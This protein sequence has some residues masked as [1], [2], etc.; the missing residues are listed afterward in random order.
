MIKIRL[1]PL[2][3]LLIGLTI[4]FIV[5][6]SA[7]QD[8]N[9]LE[10]QRF[11]S[12]CLTFE[13]KI[14]KQ[15]VANAQ[16][17]YSS[18]AFIASSDTI[19]RDEWQEFQFLN[20]SHNELL[21]IQG[22]GYSIIVGKKDLDKLEMK[23]QKEG[24]PNFKVIPE[25]KRDLYSVVLFI[26]P[27]TKRNMQAL[28]FDGYSESVRREAMI[29]ACDN[30]Y[31]TISDKI[32]L[33]QDSGKVNEP[34]VI[35]F[36]PVFKPGSTFVESESR[37]SAIKGWVF[38]TYRVNE[39]MQN[40]LGQWNYEALQLKIYDDKNLNSDNLLFDSD[41]VYGISH[42]TKKDQNLKITVNLNGN[43]WILDFTSFRNH[44][45]TLPLRV[46][47][48]VIN[49]IIISLL[50]FV[51]A[52]GLINA[53]TKSLQI[54]KLND[55][56]KKVNKNKDRFISLLAH[57]LKSP[58]NSLLGFSELLS[59]N[60]NELKNEDLAMYVDRIYTSAQVSY[61]LLE[62]L[63]LWA[64][65]Q[66]DQFPCN[67][68]ILNINEICDSMISDHQLVAGKKNISV[69]FFAA[70]GMQ[71][72]AD[73]LMVKTILRNLLVNAIKFTKPGGSVQVSITKYDNRVVISV[74][75]T[76]IGMSAEEKTLLFEITNLKSKPGTENER[77][78]GLG[79][80]LCKDMVN[81]NG[82]DIWVESTLGKGSVFSFSLP[83][84]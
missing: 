12:L 49:G 79:L 50:L 38:C 59:E 24:Y 34:G 11:E 10:K 83:L 41:F 48:I 21:G 40:M 54:Q 31:V 53:R 43:F 80:M 17:L 84:A 13:G 20:K 3:I 32:F 58:F 30:D 55:E 73:E 2:L 66:S 75:D 39:L 69:K 22:I 44:K 4:T 52:I 71:V 1:F 28:G 35:V 19:S 7:F 65:V 8:H 76:G 70:P 9:K 16:T 29:E 74:A 67:P 25:G 15:F 77:G 82:G 37:K 42:S 68:E 46:I 36:A 57:D 23:I 60:L 64:R 78:T 61:L 6:Y 56:L 72:R 18:A 47:I 63:L 5:S 33:V 27:Q 62:E 26:E 45:Y 51:L 81:K 14:Q